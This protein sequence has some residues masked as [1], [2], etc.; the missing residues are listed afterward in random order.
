MRDFNIT[1]KSEFDEITYDKNTSKYY[2]IHIWNVSTN[3]IKKSTN[4]LT[5]IKHSKQLLK[6]N[7][8]VICQI[9]FINRLAFFFSKYS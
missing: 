5:N 2:G 4:R 7:I 6:S 1:V 8:Q 9:L 3:V